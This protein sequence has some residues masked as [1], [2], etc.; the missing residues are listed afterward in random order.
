MSRQPN[1]AVPPAETNGKPIGRGVS[2]RTNSKG[3]KLSAIAMKDKRKRK[4]GM[5]KKSASLTSDG[6]EQ[7]NESDSNASDSSETIGEDEEPN[8]VAPSDSNRRKRGHQTGLSLSLSNTSIGT[9]HGTRKR[10][11]SNRVNEE[12]DMTRPT[13]A[14]KTVTGQDDSDDNY[15]GVDMISESDEDR[16]EREEEEMIIQSEE[17][18]ESENN[19]IRSGKESSDGWDGFP[20][21]GVTVEEN[22]FFTEHFGR[23]DPYS[24]NALYSPATTNEEESPKPAPARRVRFADDLNY[25]TSSGVSTTSDT[26]EQDFFPDLFL[27]QDELD[28]HFRRIIEQ[29]SNDSEGSYWDLGYNGEDLL[30]A[31]EADENPESEG[32]SSGYESMY[33]VF[34]CKPIS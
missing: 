8:D 6:N 22:T 9:E 24:S 26:T 30:Q 15:D 18:Y 7:E 25:T 14:S 19:T 16:L 17:E 34:C 11:W 28:P 13:K 23:T 33:C 1:K 10:T 4:L 21:N 32:S 31:P 12:D 29:D 3:V 5:N 2:G 20:D 27:Q